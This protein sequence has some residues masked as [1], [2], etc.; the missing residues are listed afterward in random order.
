MASVP[1]RSDRT[2][3]RREDEPTG[4]RPDVTRTTPLADTPL[5]LH[6]SIPVA[7]LEAARRFYVDLLGCRLGRTEPGRFD[8]D[9]FGHHVSVGAV[10]VASCSIE[11]SCRPRSWPIVNSGQMTSKVP[12]HWNLP[13]YLM[14][15]DSAGLTGASWLI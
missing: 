11:T 5:P 7:D 15:L 9:F 12:S 4:A 13:E 2:N 3:G 14:I 10:T 8:F 6:L 1:S